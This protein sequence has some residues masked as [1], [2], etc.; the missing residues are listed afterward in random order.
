[1]SNDTSGDVE[2]TRTFDEAYVK[3]LR[4]E[5][6][7]YRVS[8]REKEQEL[9]TFKGEV[10]AQQQEGVLKN[11]EAYAEELG[12]VDPSMIKT[13]L[14]EQMEGIMSGDVDAK[15]AVSQYLEQKPYLKQGTVGKPSNPASNESRTTLFS[16]EEISRMSPDEINNN[17]EMIQEQLKT[18]T[19]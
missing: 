17:W 5:A 4:Q 10:Q 12:M 14:G 7:S 3:E 16:R 2:Q 18:N 15:E 11:L 13:L 9:E 8:L 19:I 1:M 6:A